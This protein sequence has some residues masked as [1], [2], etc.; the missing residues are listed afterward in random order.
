MVDAVATQTIQDGQKMV[1]QKWVKSD[2]I[3]ACQE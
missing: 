3:C 2:A 1:V